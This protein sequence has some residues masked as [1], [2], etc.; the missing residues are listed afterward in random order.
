ML[1]DDG[2]CYAF[3][4]RGNGYARSE[5]VSTI[6]LKR[7]SDAIDAG[8]PIR[9][10]V[11]NT[12]INQD[13]KT[14]GIMLPNSQAQ[15]DLM[16]SIH[17]NAGLDPSLTAYIE[18]HGT[19][20][21]A[22]DNAEINSIHKVFC[23]GIKRA[24]PLFV[25]SIKANIGHCESASGLAGLVKTVLALEKGFIP[26]VPDV[27][28]MK[29]GLN[30]ME[31]NI[32][33]PHRLESWPQD[34]LRRAAINSFGYGGTNVAAIIDCYD[35]AKKETKCSGRPLENGVNK[36]AHH[37]LVDGASRLFVASAKS[38]ESLRANLEN[39][40]QWASN[41]ELDSHTFNCL[42]YTLTSRRTHMSMR[43]SFSARGHRDLIPAITKA[44][45]R[46]FEKPGSKQNLTFAFT[47]QGAQWYAMG[48]ELLHSR[49]AFS[50]SIEK[51]EKLLKELGACWD[52]RKELSKDQD[53][54][55][56]NR[57]EI[58]QPATTALQIALVDLLKSFG[59]RAD[60]VIGH[61]SGEIAAAYTAGALTHTSALRA[62]YHRSKVG[63]LAK[64]ATSRRGGMLVA[65]L[66]EADAVRYIN[67]VGKGK[68]SLACINSPAS[69]TISGDEDGI[70]ALKTILD[71]EFVT[72]RVLAV[73]VAY[74]SHHMRAVADRYLESLENL[75]A[76]SPH[77]NIR[78]YS[79][80]TGKE[81][82]T[83]FG[84]EYWVENLISTVRF[85]DAV[86][87]SQVAHTAEYAGSLQIFVE[88]GP[89]SALA[90]PLK[91]TLASQGHNLPY[92]YVSALVRGKDAQ[93]TV[94]ALAGALFE[95]GLDLEF[96]AVHSL[97]GNGSDK[98]LVLDL[99]PYAW[100]YSQ[101]YWHE[102]RLSKEY[103]FRKHP[104]HDLLGLRLVGSTSLEPIWRN[105]LSID[106]QPWLQEHVIDNFAILPGASLVCMAMEAA[107]QLDG[108]EAGGTIRRFHLRE[109]TYLKPIVVPDSPDKVELMISLSPLE[110]TAAAAHSSKPWR[111]FRITS[112][113]DN[114][115]WDLNC[116]GYIMLEHQTA[117]P[118]EVD[119]GREEHRLS[120]KEQSRLNEIDASC[121]QRIDPDLLY[122]EMRRNGIDYGPNFATIRELRLGD[123]QALGKVIIPNVAKCM[124]SEYIQPHSIHPA[125]FDA[126]MHIV[127]PLY[128]RHCSRGPVMLT[129]IDA[130]SVDADMVTRPGSPVTV[131]CTLSPS[132]PTSGSVDVTA[133]QGTGS[134]AIPVVKLRGEKFQGIGGSGSSVPSPL[135][136]SPFYQPRVPLKM[137]AQT[138]GLVSSICFK[139]DEVAKAP[140]KSDEIEVKAY[141]FAADEADVDVVLGKGGDSASIGECA[142][143]ITAV[144][145]NMKD[146][147]HIGER[148]CCWNTTTH[149]ASHT[150]VNGSFVQKLP[151]SWPFQMAAAIPKDMSLALYALQE[152]AKLNP[153]QIV[154]IHGAG[155][156]LGYAAAIVATQL[157]LNILAT[158]NTREEKET[159]HSV[160]DVKADHI[161][162]SGDLVLRQAIMHSTAGEGVNAVFNTSAAS[163][164]DEIMTCVA[165]FGTVV[166][167]LQPNLSTATIS[168]LAKRAIS[169]VSFDANHLLKYRP[170]M[171]SLMF[172]KVVSLLEGHTALDSVLP[173][174]AV[175]LEEAAVGLKAVQA[176]S[177]T[178]KVVL[179]AE[180][181][182]LVSV[183]QPQHASQIPDLARV[184]DA[185]AKLAAPQSQ[186]EELLALLKD[187]Q[188]S[189]ETTS[190]GL[191][192]PMLN[193]APTNGVDIS[194]S[195][196]KRVKQ[197]TSKG[198]A[199]Q[200]ILEAMTHK[201]ASLITISADQIDLHVPLADLGLDSL[202]AIEFK[203]WIGRSLGAAMRT[204]E[205]LDASGL[206]D[207]SRLV[208]ERSAFVSKELEEGPQG[209]SADLASLSSNPR[210]QV[211]AQTLQEGVNGVHRNESLNT[212]SSINDGEV[213]RNG[214]PH[215]PRYERKVNFT[216]NKLPKYPLLD[217]ETLMDSYLTTVQALASPL[218]YKN[219]L[220]TVDDFRQPGSSGRLLYERA[221]KMASDSGVENW[222]WELQLR[223]GHLNRRAPLVP[224]NS[225]WF[226]HPLSKRRHSQ[227]ERAA[228]IVWTAF[229]YKLRLEAG[230]VQPLMLNEQELTTA[231]HPWIFNANRQPYIRSDEMKRYPGNDYCVVMWQGHAFKL[232]LFEDN[233][234]ATFE[235]LFTCIQVILMQQLRRENWG[236]L[237]CDKRHSWAEVRWSIAK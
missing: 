76:S 128:S 174:K 159:L 172:R 32:R 81:K 209:S 13:G 9:A 11:R 150:R 120:S 216:I 166:N 220:R 44:L 21:Q 8:D 63:E 114:K 201:M 66:S 94:L 153:S 169:L 237:T 40:K 168:A 135:A 78:F 187:G 144:G 5:G 155:T 151:Q 97:S 196:E 165:Q 42:A 126:L 122:D 230:K 198:G 225:F 158:V 222:E 188:M 202:I 132:G 139:E 58:S 138:P 99:P 124:P 29:Q 125:T 68:L 31:R 41:R 119:E 167:V 175:P 3:D 56:I 96:E 127:L 161:F 88:I 101:R 152:V 73:D 15:E 181:M 191:L 62:A 129:S 136:T 178:G 4:S 53:S 199:R 193:G 34:G 116:R 102:S 83:G 205:I 214:H 12:G 33:V 86:V 177:Y 23:E 227:A 49:S 64:Q 16:R 51:S 52:L 74:H 217:I 207:I 59:I 35:P 89:H 211:M 194:K 118:N 195:P 61:S 183:K 79:S 84:A 82:T 219:T 1:N 43:R 149:F 200:I 213:L 143:I 25:G 203:N 7:L 37:K 226:S 100:D 231:Y 233:R 57:S 85:S 14:N 189:G 19:G 93:D 170:L 141:A 110:H 157:G 95:C 146:M 123:C 50:V 140:L 92:K 48:R 65:S 197:A 54:T 17:L 111:S 162:H 45:E 156:S 228:L 179:T 164:T 117:G 70:E 106:A 221:A 60:S 137:T 90:G 142:G 2:K 6:V 182:T 115:T 173:A 234:S 46:T 104:Y 212:K 145:S 80:V 39:I 192:M 113:S 236:L 69:S 223:H 91:Q 109:V 210:P 232:N 208:V 121:T 67:R 28:D 55:K 108:E 98:E 77:N 148:V 71:A 26:P 206:A 18:A 180:E 154:L 171:A 218:E 20:T 229:D 134:A 36:S 105:L 215:T 163:F 186:K 47:G 176:R 24:S 185:V 30:L 27:L 22:G 184:L 112:T 235:E 147:F 131:C 75:E 38:L 130:L 160:C 204:H 103:R 87:A 224:F 107:R 190:P 72:A 133:F 10:I